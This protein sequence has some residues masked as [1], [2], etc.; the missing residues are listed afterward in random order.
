MLIQLAKD[1]SDKTVLVDKFIQLDFEKGLPILA[2]EK[3]FIDSITISSID[4]G[5]KDDTDV[6]NTYAD[7]DGDDNFIFVN[8]FTTF[9]NDIPLRMY[10]SKSTQQLM[11]VPSTQYLG[12]NEDGDPYVGKRYNTKGDLIGSDVGFRNSVD[13]SSFK[14]TKDLDKVRLPEVNG[15]ISTRTLIVKLSGITANSKNKEY[16][17]TMITD[18]VNISDPRRALNSLLEL[19]KVGDLLK[20]VERIPI[21]GI[22]S[23]HI[24]ANK[25]FYLGRKIPSDNEYLYIGLDV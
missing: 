5:S 18:T 22:Y 16:M 13:Y 15:N 19:G 21:Y 17:E 4:N 12:S 1:E 8:E 14:A 24:G 23:E 11:I 9:L 20:D 7:V 2:I 10:Y 3:D 25:Y 6:K